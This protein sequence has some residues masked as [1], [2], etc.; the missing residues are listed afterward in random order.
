[1]NDHGLVAEVDQRLGTA[2]CQ[3][4]KAYI[5][6]RGEVGNRTTFEVECA[7]TLTAFNYSRVPKPPTRIKAFIVSCLVK[8]GRGYGCS[9]LELFV[10]EQ[11]C[12]SL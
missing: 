1:M 11:K 8:E 2:E 12:H 10:P 3:R 6:S 9:A 7:W 4:A 5:R